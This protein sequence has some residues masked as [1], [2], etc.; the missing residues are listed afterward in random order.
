M[1]SYLLSAAVVVLA[2]SQMGG[3][4]IRF[5]GLDDASTSDNQRSTIDT[6]GLG[7]VVIATSLGEVLEDGE[8][9]VYGAVK[10]GND[11]A[12]AG[13]RVAANLRLTNGDEKSLIV[14]LKGHTVSRNDK[15][16]ATD[17][18]VSDGLYSRSTG[19]FRVNTGE[20]SLD[21]I[22]PVIAT[23]FTVTFSDAGVSEPDSRVIFQVVTDGSNPT[24]STTGSTRV[25][26]GTVENDADLTTFHTTVVYAFK[27]TD[28]AVVGI[29]EDV[30]SP[31]DS[32]TQGTLAGGATGTF[33]ISV[34]TSDLGQLAASN[35]FL[36]HWTE[37]E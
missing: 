4:D 8:V 3:C 34:D 24:E 1:R 33:Q 15:T 23:D 12:L 31:S 5:N 30:V 9:F 25:A 13:I 2:L 6:T 29:A 21:A 28:G 18:I 11:K 37:E 17:K 16:D 26:E 20:T 36:I 22:K 35:D 27:G 19:Y 14:P 7:L 32:S 10:N